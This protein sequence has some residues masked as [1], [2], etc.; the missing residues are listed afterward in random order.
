MDMVLPE[1]GP[2]L[3]MEPAHKLTGL[4]LQGPKQ[5]RALLPTD[6]LRVHDEGL[7]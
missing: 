6:L 4:A 1:F 7:H 5:G 3:F 2:P